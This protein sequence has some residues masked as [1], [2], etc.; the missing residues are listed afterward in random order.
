MMASNLQAKT[1]YL[2]VVM[3][4]ESATKSAMSEQGP[5]ETTQ[6]DAS[7]ARK[8][9]TIIAKV[10]N[11]QFARRFSLLDAKQPAR[12]APPPSVSLA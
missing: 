4:K 10:T 1:V 3:A 2:S 8:P 11:H 12:P 7:L 6:L 5:L 9:Q